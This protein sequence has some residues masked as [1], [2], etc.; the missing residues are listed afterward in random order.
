MNPKRIHYL[1]QLIIWFIFL[2]IVINN[3]LEYLPSI[4]IYKSFG[5]IVLYSVCYVILLAIFS[6]ANTS[7]LIPKLY[8]KNKI[9]L[10]WLAIIISAA[11]ALVSFV[12]LDVCFLYPNFPNWFF[13]PLH[14]LSR[15]PYVV[16]FSV[17]TYLFKILD[18]YYVQKEEKL[19]LEKE[20]ADSELKLLKLQINPHFLFNTLNNIQALTYTNPDEASNT[21]V[22]LSNLFRYISYEGN[23]QSVSLKEEALHLNNYI[24]LACLKKAWKNKVA[25]TIELEDNMKTIEPMLLVNFIENAFKYSN[26]EEEIGFIKIELI[27]K[28]NQLHFSCSNSISVVSAPSANIGMSNVQKRLNLI[29]PATHSLQVKKD[30]RTYSVQLTITL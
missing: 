10:Y 29:Y 9:I 15:L 27:S 20:N 8:R 6:Y 18:E 19:R 2:G 24:A 4:K 21:L 22:T 23:K 12:A 30:T 16:L 3:F 17:L 25:F 26:L 13:I 7:F 1:L 11:F 5:S 14:F 28:N